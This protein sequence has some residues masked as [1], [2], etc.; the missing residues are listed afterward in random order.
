MKEAVGRLAAAEIAS[1]RVNA[2]WMLGEVLKCGRAELY[3]FGDAPVDSAARSAF[4]KM[5]ERRLRHEPLQYILGYAQFY[6]LRLRVTPAVLIPRPETEQVVERAIGLIR[7][8]SA[9]RVLDVGTGSGCIALSIKHER[10]DADVWACDVSS[11]ALDIARENAAV[12][13]L[14]IS[15]IAADVTSDAF[16][17]TAPAELDLLVSNPPYVPENERASLAAE[18]RQFEPELALFSGD[19]PLLFYYRLAEVGR[20]LLRNGGWIVLETHSET[21][22]AAAELLE[23][24]GYF[25]VMLEKDYAGRPRIL[26]GRWSSAQLRGRAIKA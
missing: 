8:V 7:E 19:N 5:L 2:E 17:L 25:D 1:P 16:F 11:A 13:E 3:A 10:A 15:I 6:G 4:G 24:A 14:T 9:P 26:Y 12:N 23:Q 21:G 20:K 22:P 18:V